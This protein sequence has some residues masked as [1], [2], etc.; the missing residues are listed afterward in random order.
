MTV[1]KIWHFD[2]L[3]PSAIDTAAEPSAATRAML[4]IGNIANHGRLSHNTSGTPATAASAAV[5]SSMRDL[6]ASA[7]KSRWLGQPTDIA[8]LDLLDAYGEDDVR[9]K[10]GHRTNE[11]PFSSER[12][13][14]GVVIASALGELTNGIGNG[15][16]TAFIKGSLEQI[17]SRSD[18][19]LTRDGQEVILDETRRRLAND[20]ARVMAEEGLRVIAFA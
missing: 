20:A 17:L 9:D 4:R 11:T 8:M 19:Y 3:Q 6:S 13:W 18:T 7:T 16:E 15:T 12:K 10:V 1:T 5:L 2:M 14:M